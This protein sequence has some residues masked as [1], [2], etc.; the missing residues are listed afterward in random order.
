M[1]QL[2]KTS[3]HELRQYRWQV[4]GRVVLAVLGGYGFTLLFGILLTY[5][6]PISKSSAVMTANLLSFAIYTGVI[7]WIFSAKNLRTIVL[8]LTSSIVVLGLL[9]LLF[10]LANGG[11]IL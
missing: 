2:K 11:V 7:V 6:L 1:A 10:K 9:T 4:L 3:E 5:T 8:G